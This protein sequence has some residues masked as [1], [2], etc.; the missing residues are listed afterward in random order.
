MGADAR[1]WQA[2]LAADFA[3]L[4]R[5]MSCD[6]EARAG[7]PT[8]A[9]ASP[10]APRPALHRCWF[11]QFSRAWPSHAP[12]PPPKAT[13]GG[14]PATPS[15]APMPPPMKAPMY[16][17]CS[18]LVATSASARRPDEGPVGRTSVLRTWREGF[19][20]AEGDLLRTAIGAIDT[21]LWTFLAGVRHYETNLSKGASS[22]GRSQNRHTVT[23]GFFCCQ[24][25]VTSDIASHRQIYGAGWRLARMVPCSTGITTTQGNATNVTIH[26]ADGDNRY[27]LLQEVAR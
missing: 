26:H 12:I 2:T 19:A 14:P 21:G 6:G 20:H 8:R 5:S 11:S 22:D 10:P 24:P 1:Q 16:R 25:A 7:I 9:R 15:T 27:R 18:R 3:D 23:A 17:S 13:P 4:G